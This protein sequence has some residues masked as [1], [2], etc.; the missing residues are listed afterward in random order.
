MFIFSGVLQIDGLNS[1]YPFL[2]KIKKRKLQI[3]NSSSE[4]LDLGGSITR[5]LNKKIS[6]SVFLTSHIFCS[7]TLNKHVA[8]MLFG[9]PIHIHTFI[10]P[11]H[12][13]LPSR[14]ADSWKYCARN[15]GILF[16]THSMKRERTLSISPI[17]SE[18]Q[19]IDAKYV[20]IFQKIISSVRRIVFLYHRIFPT[21]IIAVTIITTGNR[22]RTH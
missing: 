1:Y 14:A 18:V 21:T 2:I 15:E 4:F 16:W 10:Y 17:Y 20:Y 9:I 3:R 8:A 7:P 11:V 5:M 22:T 6:F 12:Y 19:D 13:W